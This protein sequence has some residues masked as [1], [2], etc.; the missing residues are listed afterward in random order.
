MGSTESEAK[1]QGKVAEIGQCMFGFID[2]MAFMCA[3]ELRIP[4]IIHS[5]SGSV[6]VS[7]IASSIGDSVNISFLE[8]VLR[9]LVRRGIFT[10]HHQSDVGETFYGLP[11]ACKC[12]L[13]ESE[14]SSAPMIL[15]L[16]SIMSSFNNF[17]QCVKGA[18]NGFKNTHGCSIWEYNEQNVEFASLVNK[19]QKSHCNVVSEAVISEYKEEFNNIKSLVDVGGG[20]GAMATQIAKSF[21]HIEVIN[22]DL[23]HVVKMAQPHD[24][25][26]H[27]G[28]DM[29]DSIPNADVLLL[30]GV[31][32]DWDDEAV[33]K[34]FKNCRKAI[35][36]KTG[37]LII[38]DNILRPEENSNHVQFQ[39]DL[40]VHVAFG[41][42]QRTELEWKKLLEKGGFPSYKII[43]LPTMQS[44][45]EAYP[46]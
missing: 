3:V 45:I 15:L 5:H 20:I 19:S 35:P 2:S 44:A 23:P 9:L 29:F 22:Y 32:T 38:I 41:G 46:Y 31:V 34:I 11:D 21:P 40:A 30:K 36:E 1:S 4:D 10:E 6:T 16:K 17:T 43:K 18:G 27:L 13:W 26:S 8:K 39:I 25:V 14:Q 24:G 37:K 42:N 33:I 28:G 7:Q 12:L